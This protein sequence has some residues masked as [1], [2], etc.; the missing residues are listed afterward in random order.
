MSTTQPSVQFNGADIA[1]KPAD[2]INLRE[3]FGQDF[4]IAWDPAY[5]AEHGPRA[6][7]DDV[8]LQVIEGRLGHIYPHGNGLLA[9]SSNSRGPVAN[10]LAGVAGATVIQ[11][12]D[13]GVTI[14]F[15]VNNF[16]TVAKIIRARTCRTTTEAQLQALATGG[17]QHRFKK[18]HKAANRAVPA[19]DK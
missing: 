11:D 12:G 4:R 3:Q 2:P 19:T 9:A 7:I 8:W 1:V 15:P 13:D 14:A 6:I 5:I 16:R 10:K 18:G 17:A